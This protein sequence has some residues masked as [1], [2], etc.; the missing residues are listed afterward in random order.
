MT[1]NTDKTLL[2]TIEAKLDSLLS[3]FGP[4]TDT[5][6]QKPLCNVIKQFNPDELK[7]IEPLYIAGG[8]VDGHRDAYKDPVKGPQKLVKA[9]AEGRKANTL[10][11]S[12]FHNHKTKG[13]E[14]I[15]EWVNVEEAVLEDGTVVP[16]NM[17][18]GLIKFNN[19]A[20]YNMRVEGRI[21]GLSMGAKGLVEVV[22]DKDYS[23]LLTSI[24]SSKTP[25]RV[26]SDFIFTHKAAHYAY[27]SW[28]QGGAASNLN[29]PIAIMKSK[30]KL[31]QKEQDILDEI[32]EEYEELDK[33][34]ALPDPTVETAPSTSDT[35]ALDAGVDNQTINKG[36]QM[37]VEQSPEYQMIVKKLVAMEVKEDLLPF[38]L[39]KSIASEA[40]LA[41][42]ELSVEHR[43]SIFK[44]FEAMKASSDEKDGVIEGLQGDLTKSLSTPTNTFNP[45]A[46]LL[47]GEQGEGTVVASAPEKPLSSSK[48]AVKLF[49]K[50]HTK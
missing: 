38:K 25:L 9:I 28:D 15:D 30:D 14:I 35:E 29:E 41:L 34:K 23:K 12:L 46:D 7:V 8:S 44:A 3:K 48:E 42:A 45:I 36:Q 1:E 31:T 16:A 32:K 20:L 39:E 18:L 21:G 40:S 5:P 22:G 13:F 24:D 49:N 2:S 4:T 17:P 19:E 50:K 26:I 6:P 10:Q 27:T 37:S 47:K 11:Y 33:A 43:S